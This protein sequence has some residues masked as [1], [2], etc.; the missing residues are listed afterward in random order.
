[1][2]KSW[3]LVFC[4]DGKRISYLTIHGYDGLF[5]GLIPW[6][7]VIRSGEGHVIWFPTRH[8]LDAA[9]M[10]PKERDSV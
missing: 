8:E 1:M 6:R 4:L 3:G 5:E 10:A 9:A 2:N 7:G